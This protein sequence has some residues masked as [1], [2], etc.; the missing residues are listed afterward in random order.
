MLLGSARLMAGQYLN[1]G[2]SLVGAVSGEDSKRA[3]SF[4]TTLLLKID[5]PVCHRSHHLAR[6]LTSC[7]HPGLGSRVSKLSFL[8]Y[9]NCLL[10]RHC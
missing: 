2:V 10:L 8:N 3:G 4:I 9:S 6:H 5:N 7:I 1:S